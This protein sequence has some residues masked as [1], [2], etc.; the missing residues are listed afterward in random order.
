MGAPDV[1]LVTVL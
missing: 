1:F